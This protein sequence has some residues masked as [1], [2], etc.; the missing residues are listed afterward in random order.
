MLASF[1]LLFQVTLKLI[2]IIHQQPSY[3]S[4]YN[5]MTTLQPTTGTETRHLLSYC[6]KNLPIGVLRVSCLF[7][8]FDWCLMWR[9][10]RKRAYAPDKNFTVFR[11]KPP[12]SHLMDVPRNM[13]KQYLF[14]CR[15]SSD[16][17]LK[18]QPEAPAPHLPPQR[19]PCMLPGNKNGVLNP[20]ILYLRY[21]KPVH[22][23]S[24]FFMSLSYQYLL[25]SCRTYTI[26]N[27][28]NIWIFSIFCLPPSLKER[29]VSKC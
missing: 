1:L 27:S 3:H 23:G 2:K 19:I 20:E 29:M 24:R 28:V 8:R 21:R 17:A 15:T 9:E 4:T 6:T 5:N 14:L 18:H 12:T 10:E 13:V 26:F 25:G 11:C 16:L 7:G 22:I